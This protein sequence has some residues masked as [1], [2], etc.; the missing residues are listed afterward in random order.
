LN[1]HLENIDLNSYSGPNSFA[2]KFVN[3]VEGCT[4]DPN[5]EAAAHLCFI[6]THKNHFEKPLFLRL[7]G[8][9]VNAKQDHQRQNY[10]IKRTYDLAKGVIFQSEFG[11]K[12]IFKTFGEHPNYTIITNGA[13]T[14]K[15]SETEPL[16]Y[17]KYENVWAC[18]SNW[19]P[20]KRLD[21]NIRYFLE[22]AGPNDGLIVAGAVPRNQQVQAKNIH[23][24]GT[25]NQKQLFSLYKRSTFLIHLA[26]LDCCPN[27]VVDA[28]ACGCKI[29]CTDSGGT[30]EIAGSDAIVIKDL[31]WNFEPLDLYNPCEL[32]F[33]NFSDLNGLDSEVDMSYVSK[34]YINFIKESLK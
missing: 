7:D 33:S 22:Q 24:V 32:D 1:I 11:K 15:I 13:D 14:R 34:R 16:K 9:Y 18:A 29:I 12:L 19:R 20:H 4:F 23:Y 10:N 28:R 3:Y 2:N 25:L 17:T 21:S 5:K 8:I 31:D 6:E 27:V 30:R 26:S